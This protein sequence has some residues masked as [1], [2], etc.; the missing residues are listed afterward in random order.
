MATTQHARL[1][2]VRQLSATFVG[3]IGFWVSATACSGATFESNGVGASAGE[4]T[5][6]AATSGGSSH[7]GSPAAAGSDSAG[8]DAGGM[9][10]GGSDAGGTTSAGSDTGGSATGGSA[11]GGSAAGGSAMGGSATGGSAAG[12]TAS[13]GSTGTGGSTAAA[14][15]QDSD[16]AVCAYPTVPEN[17]T[18]CYCTNCPTSAM[19]KSQ[20]DANR[21][22]YEKVCTEPLLCP[23]IAC[24]RPPTPACH[25][26][27]CVAAQ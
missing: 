23:A 3:V 17:A 20:C 26:R 14:C 2:I 24:T 11:A 6:G 16:C 27:R 5:S 9:T 1:E 4:A 15:Q 19:L 10:V 7:G 13:A 12:G 8:S 22:A 25:D 18:Q 21:R